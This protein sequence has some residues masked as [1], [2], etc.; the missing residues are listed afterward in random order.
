MKFTLKNIIFFSVFLLS[1]SSIFLYDEASAAE[2]DLDTLYEKAKSGK[3]DLSDSQMKNL[4]GDIE[5]QINKNESSGINTLLKKSEP[6]VQTYTTAEIIESNEDTQIISITAFSDIILDE[7]DLGIPQ[8]TPFWSGDIKDSTASVRAYATLNIEA[9]TVNNYAMLRL[10]GAS[11]GWDIVDSRVK[12]ITNRSVSYANVGSS[13]SGAVSQYLGPYSITANTFN[14]STQLQSSTT[15]IH[16]DTA[17]ISATTKA[18]LS[19][20]LTSWDMQMV[21][22]NERNATT[23]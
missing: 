10:L 4:L 19:S 13:S 2:K 18:T 6:T 17:L 12:F 3:S 23:N 14:N 1:L 9:K 5:I 22:R 16:K 15:L 21:L 11:G 8:I 7:L 20:S